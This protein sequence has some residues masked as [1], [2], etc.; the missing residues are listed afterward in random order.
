MTPVVDGI[1]SVAGG[2]TFDAVVVIEIS[3]AALISVG[4]SRW[5]YTFAISLDV[6]VFA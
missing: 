3:C 6:V 1:V 5:V 4:K 2:I